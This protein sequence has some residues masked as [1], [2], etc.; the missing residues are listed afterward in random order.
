VPVLELYHDHVRTN[1]L[2]MVTPAGEALALI[3]SFLKLAL[4]LCCSSR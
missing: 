3:N 2:L 1:A 4:R